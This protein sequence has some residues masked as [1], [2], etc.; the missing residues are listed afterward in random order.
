MSTHL[1]N[2]TDHFGTLAGSQTEPK[3]TLVDGVRKGPQRL[4]KAVES[5][6]AALT[7]KSPE[8]QL[9]DELYGMSDRDLADIGVCRGDIPAIIDG[10][11]EVPYHRR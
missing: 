1:T 4:L 3:S 6:F 2:P 5:G 7:R 8:A 9:S 10:T 11:F